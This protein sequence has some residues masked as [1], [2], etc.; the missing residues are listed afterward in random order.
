MFFVPSSLTLA[1]A[2]HVVIQRKVVDGLR[3]LF[4]A[5]GR[6]GH[7][8]AGLQLHNAGRDPRLP[9]N[10]RQVVSVAN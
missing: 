1:E 2:G 7:L 6:L 8:L 10:Q 5:A 4:N 9:L 3:H